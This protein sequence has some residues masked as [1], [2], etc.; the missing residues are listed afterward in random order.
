MRRCSLA[1]M[2]AA[3]LHACQAWLLHARPSVPA[4]RPAQ[5][6]GGRVVRAPSGVMHGKTSPVSHDNTGLLHGLDNP[7]K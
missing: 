5:V 4:P 1:G 3:A 2:V 7:F 6:F